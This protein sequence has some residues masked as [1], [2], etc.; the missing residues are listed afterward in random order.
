[1]ER[2]KSIVMSTPTYDM[3]TLWQPL[4]VMALPTSQKHFNKSLE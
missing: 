4:I 3:L 2:E 1:M